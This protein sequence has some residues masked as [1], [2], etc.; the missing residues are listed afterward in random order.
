MISPHGDHRSA[1][2]FIL[3]PRLFASAC[4]T[5]PALC[6]YITFNFDRSSALLLIY[7]PCR[8]PKNGESSARPSVEGFNLKLLGSSAIR[9]TYFRAL[10]LASGFFRDAER[11]VAPSPS[12]PIFPHHLSVLKVCRPLNDGHQIL[13]KILDYDAH[14]AIMSANNKRFWG[15]GQLLGQLNPN[16]QCEYTRT[17]CSPN[18]C[19]ENMSSLCR[20]NGLLR[21]AFLFI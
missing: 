17:H 2:I 10:L 11:D 7:C 5:Q 1:S 12:L 20:P 6:K 18:K 8:R 14:S 15:D 3:Y 19:A 16:F 4:A 9:S 13:W 21:S